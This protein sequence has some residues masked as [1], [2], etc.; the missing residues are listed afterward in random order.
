[1][2]VLHRVGDATKIKFHMK[3]WSCHKHKRVFAVIL[4]LLCF[5]ML[6]AGT[7]GVLGHTHAISIGA[8]Q[9]APGASINP[10]LLKLSASA[11][12]SSGALCNLCFCYRLLDQSLVPQTARIIDSPSIVQTIHIRRICPI[13][14][15]TLAIGNRGPP[16]A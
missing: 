6:F 10:L 11:Q 1:M 7:H 16:Q 14:I 8:T 3:R 12:D 5:G 15:P 13:R 4:I 9:S 2:K